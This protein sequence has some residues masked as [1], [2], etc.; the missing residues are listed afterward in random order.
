MTWS[1]LDATAADEVLPPA[2]FELDDAAVDVIAGRGRRRI[3][4]E[5]TLSVRAEEVVAVVGASGSG[6]TTLLR[7]LGGMV[8]VSAG[9]VRFAGTSVRSIPA[10]VVTVFQDYGNALLPWRTVSRNVALGLEGK[11]G[12]T[13]RMERVDEALALV[14]LEHR[15]GDRPWQLSGGMQQRVQIAR[16]LAVR[17]R[18]LLMDEPFGALDALTRADL[19]D[20]LLAVQKATR[21]TIV[22]ITH[23][24]DE[25]LYLA[26]RVVV[27]GN[28]PATVIRTFDVDL[29]RPR[30][31]VLTREDAR[32]IRLRHEV[33][34]T[35]L[36]ASRKS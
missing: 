26:D 33:L 25:A 23:D 29:D 31:Q 11:V 13:E 4:E 27:L 5:V 24:V 28:S 22:F 9:V 32:Y 15:G 34:E 30:D 21:A 12:R 1:A 16:A 18:V 20:Q 3:L 35:M 8:P 17:P 10:G 2:L 19:Q 36:S 6:K 7:L 14:G